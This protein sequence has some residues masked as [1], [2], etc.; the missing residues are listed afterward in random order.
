MNQYELWHET[1]LR[2]QHI[3]HHN[4]IRMED[5]DNVNQYELCDMKPPSAS[6]TLAI[7]M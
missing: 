7:I 5:D 6:N 3:S 1:T 4:V 2:K